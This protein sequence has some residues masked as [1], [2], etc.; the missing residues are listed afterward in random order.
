MERTI[1][2]LSEKPIQKIINSQ[3][4]IKLGQFMFE[5]PDVG[6]T[7]TKSRK[8][9]GLNEIYLEDKQFHNILLRLYNA[10]CNQITIKKWTKGCILSFPKKFDLG[11][12]NNY[13]EINLTAVI[14]VRFISL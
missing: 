10:L 13:C 12:T 2:N 1:P 8:S 14:A 7:K 9:A 11:I 3:Q 6:L 5:E 4:D